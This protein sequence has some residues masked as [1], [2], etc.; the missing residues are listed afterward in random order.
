[1]TVIT[2]GTDILCY[3]DEEVDIFSSRR[4]MG[5]LLKFRLIGSSGLRFRPNAFSSQM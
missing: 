4:R 1:M 3:G 2:I 5:D